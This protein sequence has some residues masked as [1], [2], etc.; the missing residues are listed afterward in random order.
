MLTK[1]EPEGSRDASGDASSLLQPGHNVWRV[2]TANR[3]APLIDAGAYFGALRAAMLRARETITIVG[4]DMDSQMRLLGEGCAADDGLPETFAAFLTALAE[5]NPRLNIRLLL[6]DY[7]V[8]F[9]LDREL[10]PRLRLFWSTPPQI[11]LC[12]DDE[13]PLGASQHQKIVVI[14]D[15]VAFSGGIDLTRRRWD[16]PEHKLEDSRRTDPTGSTYRPFHDVQMAVDGDAA[17]ALG[18]L[19][20]ERWR[21]AT[22]ETL[23]PVEISKEEGES[24]DP[25]DPWPSGLEPLFRDVR[26][27]IAR[28]MPSRAGREGICEVQHLW[29]DMI[30]RAERLVYLENQFVTARAVAE[31]LAQRMQARPELEAVI[32]S[33]GTYSEWFAKDT[34]LHGRVRFMSVLEEAGVADRVRLLHPTVHEGDASVPIMVHAKVTIVDDVWLRIGSANL[35]N[36]SMG[37]DSECDL[38][39]EAQSAEDRAAVAETRNRLIGEH[40][41]LATDEFGARLA[42]EGS[43]RTVLDGAEAG[44]RRLTEIVD[45]RKDIVLP[46]GSIADPPEPLYDLPIGGQG[47]ENKR[48]WPMALKIGLVLAAFALIVLA[49]QYSPL[50][51]PQQLTE[52]FESIAEQPLAPI[53]VVAVFVAGGLIAFPITVLILAT[54]AVF[55]SWSGMLLAAVGAMASAVVTYFAGWQLGQKSLRRFVGPRINRIRRGMAEQG[56]VTVATIRLVPVAPFTLV[57]LVAGAMRVRFLDYCLGTLLGLAPG[58]LTM[59]L[60]AGQVM[61]VISNPTAGR[62]AVFAGLVLLWGLLMFGLQLLVRRYRK[63]GS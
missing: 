35:C 55:G 57:N 23:A 5:R 52:A 16:T 54:V 32:V 9:S 56:I 24:E 8:L 29:F 7:S 63:S 4:W 51:E 59:T 40:T 53:I 61:D 45:D 62:I 48:W 30:D 13:L 42:E 47:D 60:L 28:T 41:G 25:H 3:A 58:L 17:R 38:I 33:P 26:V 6:W 49:W 10:A 1:N 20:R 27:G 39:V 15:Q 43:V 21:E 19:V 31:R 37:F 11:E 12:L 18:D 50:S 34:M 2:E 22:D 36:R 46:L 14:D 44:R